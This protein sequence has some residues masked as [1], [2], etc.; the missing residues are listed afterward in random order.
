MQVSDSRGRQPFGRSVPP[1]GAMRR[2]AVES[3][4]L[5]RLRDEL[6]LCG[7]ERLHALCGLAPDP[8]FTLCKLLWLRTHQPEVLA[9]AV[10][11][12]NVTHYLAWRLCG[13]MTCD[14]TLASRTL[15][16]DL[17]RRVWSDDLIA[18]AGLARDLFAPIRPNGARLYVFALSC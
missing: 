15:A 4:A 12:L 1:S 10:R 17:H 6:G 13:E 3:E 18:A 9:R 14:P 5:V 8:T 7:R 16:F 2:A 11:W